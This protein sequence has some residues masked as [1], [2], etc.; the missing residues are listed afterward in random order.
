MPAGDSGYCYAHNPDLAERRAK[1]R[2]NGGR[3]GGKSR[4]AAMRKRREGQS[5]SERLSRP[6]VSD[7]GTD[8]LQAEYDRLVAKPSP[9]VDDQRKLLAV[10]QALCLR[11]VITANQLNAVAGASRQIERYAKPEPETHDGA[12]REAALLAEL[13]EQEARWRSPQ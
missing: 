5:H 8:A 4:A 9:S 12:D 11:G 7:L 13:A 1:S 2:G 10:C 6:T 3:L